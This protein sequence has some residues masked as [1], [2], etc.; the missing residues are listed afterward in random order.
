MAVRKDFINFCLTLVEPAFISAELYIRLL[1]SRFT[2]DRARR[3]APSHEA[4]RGDAFT[5]VHIRL[6]PV[7]PRS[8]LGSP[9]LL[10][11]L[12]RLL[13][14]RE[15]RHGQSAHTLPG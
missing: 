7:G 15:W 13:P 11:N 5:A 10:P 4:T 3:T 14:P 12:V 6:G 2:E 8:L 9:R 1:S